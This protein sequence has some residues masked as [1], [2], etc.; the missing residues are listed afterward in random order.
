MAVSV[1]ADEGDEEQHDKSNGGQAGKAKPTVDETLQWTRHC[2]ANTTAI[3]R[4]R[5]GIADSS[6]N[7]NNK[8]LSAAAACSTGALLTTA[9]FYPVELVKNRLQA[10]ALGDGGFAYKGLLDGLKTVFREEGLKGL[11]IGINSIMVRAVSSDFLT[12]WFGER[13]ISGWGK[14]PGCNAME[15]P[16][17]IAGGW[18]SVCITM[19]LETISTRV[20]CA[21]PPL[22]T[23][24]AIR[25]LWKEGRFAAFWRGLRVMLVL[26]VNPALTFTA[27]GWIRSAYFAVCRR[28][29]SE[30]DKQKSSD[31][32]EMLSWSEAFVVGVVA[33]FLTLSVVY[34]LIRAKFLLQARGSSGLGLLGV[35]KRTAATE[36]YSSLY[37]GL[38]AQLSK[39]L[40]SAALTL[41]V[42]ERTQK[43]WYD[44]L[45]STPKVIKP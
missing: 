43:W 22:T 23:S 1:V 11:F 16:L 32:E 8:A 36:G 13:F 28:L 40:L 5:A 12:M 35:L 25:E 4:C 3:A 10:A 34:P 33:K 18:I 14:G 44:S 20:T 31:K 41:A 27:F 45:M 7:A 9:M 6:V 17:R 15:L 42:K 29:K 38:D 21:R 39:S 19:P 26:C 2:S 37:K 30:L 24:G